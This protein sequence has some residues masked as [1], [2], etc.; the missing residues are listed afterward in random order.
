MPLNKENKQIIKCNQIM[1]YA[2]ELLN[3]IQLLS[4]H[5]KDSYLKIESFIMDFYQLIKI[6]EQR[7]K[8]ITS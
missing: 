7:N 3:A 1:R 2:I 4:I 5:N 8:Y 6:C